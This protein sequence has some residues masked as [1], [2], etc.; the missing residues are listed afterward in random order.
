MENEIPRIF[1]IRK[2]TGN[3]QAWLLANMRPDGREAVDCG[4]FRT[5]L[6]VDA[7]LKCAGFFALR[8]GDK[9]EVVL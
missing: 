4:S 8:A 1:R 6:S 5:A 2:C 3:Q 9:V 7:L